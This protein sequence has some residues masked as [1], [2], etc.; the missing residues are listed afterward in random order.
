MARP[1]IRRRARWRLGCWLSRVDTHLLSGAARDDSLTSELQLSLKRNLPG[2]CAAAL[3]EGARGGDS[4]ELPVSIRALFPA[5][6]SAS[7]SVGFPSPTRVTLL[8]GV[9][10]S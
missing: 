7:R 1:P 9:L 8:S 10:I 6:R 4:V 3:S 5:R 2:Q